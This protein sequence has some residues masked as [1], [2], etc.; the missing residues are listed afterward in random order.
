MGFQT[1]QRWPWH[2]GWRGWW[3]GWHWVVFFGWNFVRTKGGSHVIFFGIFYFWSCFVK[4][5]QRTQLSHQE[6]GKTETNSS[7]KRFYNLPQI[8]EH[9]CFTESFEDNSHLLLRT[10]LCGSNLVG[11][12]WKLADDPKWLH[13]SLTAFPVPHRTSGWWQLGTQVR[14]CGS[15]KWR[16]FF[17]WHEI[18]LSGW[19]CFF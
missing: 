9:H 16:S 12:P 6:W 18:C 5:C 1:G 13:L 10:L 2:R 4:S 19:I 17:F 14:W 3:T 8:L 7:F 11:F 15:F